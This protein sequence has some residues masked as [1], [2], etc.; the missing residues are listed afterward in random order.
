MKLSTLLKGAAVV[1]ATAQV[2]SM[3]ARLP[4]RMRLAGKTVLV[5]GGSRGLGRAV[6]VELAKRG[7]KVA[8]CARSQRDL[9]VVGAELVTLG[10][11]VHAEACDLRDM[12]Q[13]QELVSNVTASLG[14]IDVLVH[15]AAILTAGPI[16]SM[17]VADFDDSMDSIF[18]TALHASLAV[19]PGMRARR[20][21]T[22]ALI[23]SIGGKVAVP[24]LV[25]YS[26]AKFAEVG[27]AEG[28][29]AESVKDGINVLNVVPGLMRTGAHVHALVKGDAE[30]EY[31]WFGAS[32]TAPGPFTIDSARAARRVVRA[33][34]R[35]DRE[36][37]LTPMA[38][39][40][41]AMKALT[42]GLMSFAMEIAGRLLPRAPALPGGGA[43][44]REGIELEASSPSEAVAFVARR[45]RPLANRNNQLS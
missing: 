4:R 7:C 38:Q 27:L 1:L 2:A 34:E 20:S 11:T 12:A 15:T 17:T 29:R 25:P 23:T 8:I 13:V 44:H 40:A 35:G 30:K 41:V 10:A 9:D 18:K 26:A 33:I 37:V 42:P 5:C 36:I 24:H 32:A 43:R 19:L 28:L 45:G 14:P 3:A 21:G 39:L 6:A 31:A 16:E 22:I